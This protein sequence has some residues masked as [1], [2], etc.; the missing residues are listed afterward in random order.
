MW[1]DNRFKDYFSNVK[2]VFLYLIDDCNLDCIQCLYKTNTHFYLRDKFIPI[3]VAKELLS[4]MREL[5][6]NKLT[7]MGG[8]PTLYYKNNNN[9]ELLS[10]IEYANE[11]GYSYIR[12]DTNGTFD[13]ALLD[14]PSFKLLSEITFSLDG[15]NAYINDAIRGKGVFEKCV[16][17]IEYA[18]KCGYNCNITCCIHKGLIERNNEGELYLDEMIL[19]AEKIGISRINF[20]DL[21][22]SNIPRDFWTGNIDISVDQ[23]YKMWNEIKSLQIAGRYSIPVRIPQGVIPQDRFEANKEY[24]GYCSAKNGDRVLIHPNGIIRICSLLIGTPYGVAR[25]YNQ[26]IVWDESTTNEL[27]GY[28]LSKMTPCSNQSR[29]KN[30]NTYVPVCVSFKPEQDEFAWNLLEWEKRKEER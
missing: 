27:E 22:K 7:L 1:I 2:Q 17:N 13:K 26:K 4:S 10:L 16:N 20:H 3:N 21:F 6:A 8:E 30:Y 28:D 9:I 15:P 11:I 25:Y 5:G 18:L 19:F 29:C 23:W 14:N 24:Y 12:I